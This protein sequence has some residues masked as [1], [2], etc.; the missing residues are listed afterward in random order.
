MQCPQC[1][2][3]NPES[4][5]CCD[6]GYIFEPSGK[7]TTAELVQRQNNRWYPNAAQWRVLWA[8]AAILCIGL[9]TIFEA[10]GILIDAVI[11][12]GLLFWRFSR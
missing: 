5:K 10:A 9:P 1:K 7:P 6:C 3:V 12:G 2:L 11:I 4:A 8:V